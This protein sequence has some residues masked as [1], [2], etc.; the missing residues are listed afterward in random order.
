MRARHQ[1]AYI[2]TYRSCYF[3]FCLVSRG[4]ECEVF[5]FSSSLSLP[6]INPDISFPKGKAPRHA[7]E[8]VELGKKKKKKKKRDL[9][10]EGAEPDDPATLRGVL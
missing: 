6:L 10:N 2:N 4:D 1:R 3:L 5:F 9:A 7:N 8:G